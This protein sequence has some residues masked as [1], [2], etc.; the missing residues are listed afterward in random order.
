[1]PQDM[2][3]LVT[4]MFLTYALTTAV[5]VSFWLMNRGTGGLARIVVSLAAT[6]AGLALA[7]GFGEASSLLHIVGIYMFLIIGHTSAWIGIAEFWHQKTRRLVAGVNLLGI[8]TL[9]LILGYHMQGGS[10]VG[11]QA[12]ISAFLAFCS[13][14][15]VFTILRAKGLTIDI[16]ESAFRES[17]VGS[18]V[19]ALLFV[20]H[21]LLNA[22]RTLSWPQLGIGTMFDPVEGSYMAAATLM[23]ALLFSPIFVL[24]V[25]IMVAERLQTEL[26]VE[27]MLEPVTRSLNRRAFLTV[28]K[29]VLAR[30]RRNADAVSIL[31]AEVKNFKDIRDAAG[32]TGCDAIMKQIATAIVAGRREQD[33]FSRFSNDEFL[34]ILPGTPEEGAE[35]VLERVEAEISGRSYNEKGKAIDVNVTLVTHTSRGDD[36]EAEGMVDAAAKKLASL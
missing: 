30:A 35:Q 36:L 6:G 10:T 20:F 22:Y 17:R 25:I 9:V 1:M 16:Y 26:R 31:L 4:A 33:V 12:I 32:R 14:G 15:I 27:Q 5:L 8:V 3:P 24:G 23:E 7:F 18:Y 13:A 19:L 11:R 2:T 28:T 29:L 21:G 34:L